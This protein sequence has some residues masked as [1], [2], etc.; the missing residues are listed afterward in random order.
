MWSE[1]RVSRRP[2]EPI[3]PRL[4]QL[5]FPGDGEWGLCV[6][7]SR[8]SAPSS[9]LLRP[10]R[11]VLLTP[12]STAAG[13]PPPCPSP[14]SVGLSGGSWRQAPSCSQEP[15]SGRQLSPDS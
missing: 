9:C 5:H 8:A 14:A 7:W 10:L 6:G 2:R 13:C 11:A 15:G 1:G 12:G 4:P 3:F